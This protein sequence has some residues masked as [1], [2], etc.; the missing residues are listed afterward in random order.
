MIDYLTMAL[1]VVSGAAF[2][3][4]LSMFVILPV[5]NKLGEICTDG[6]YKRLF[7]KETRT[8]WKIKLLGK[9]LFFVKGDVIAMGFFALLGFFMY[10]GVSSKMQEGGTLNLFDC[11][12][13]EVLSAMVTAALFTVVPVYTTKYLYRLTKATKKLKATLGAHINDKDAHNV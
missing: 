13:F 10:I 11:E 1:I 8:G 2:P 7:V 4:M 3:V 5:L 6:D 9:K 12:G